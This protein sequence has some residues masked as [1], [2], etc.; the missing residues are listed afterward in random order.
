MSF[1]GGDALPIQVG[2]TGNIGS[3]KSSVARLL[4]QRD[5]AVLVDADEL[6]RQATNDSEVL[7]RIASD[8]GAGLVIGGD[9]GAPRLDRA[10]TAEL[11]F[12]DAAAL[13]RLNG[14]IHPWVGRRRDELVAKYQ[15]AAEPPAVIV[16]DIPLLYE[17]DLD[18]G[19]DA[20]IVVTAPLAARV[21]RVVARSGLEPQEVARRDAHQMPLETKAARADFVVDNAG[22]LA[23]LR[24]QVARLWTELLALRERLGTKRAATPEARQQGS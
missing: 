19:L 6:A 1:P 14:I 9:D 3:G 4:A 21:A 8:L 5:G 22:D 17:N 15:G 16:H 13:E 23:D 2:L 20:V 10:A 12:A 24:V 11:V 7:S 18:S